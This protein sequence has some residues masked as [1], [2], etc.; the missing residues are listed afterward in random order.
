MR[1]PRPW[2]ALVGPTA[3]GKTEAGLVVAGR[4]GAEILSVDSMLVYRGM[5]VGTA[6]PTAEERARV[7]HHMLD[8]GAPGESFSVSRF[9][10]LA[11]RAL[12]D[13]G[14]RGCGV[15]LVGGSGLYFRS[16]VDGLS[17]PGTDPGTRFDLEREAE[18]LGPE[19][20]YARLA[21]LDPAAAAKIE[22]GN[23]RRTV[24]ALEVAAVTGRPFSAFAADWGRYPP[25]AVRAAGVDVDPA[26]LRARI[27]DRARSM[28][29]GGLVEEV[30]TLLERGAGPS[31]TSGQA[32]GYAEVIEHLT[33][34]M[35]LD[36]A[37]ARTVKRTRA[38]ARRQM[39]WFRRDPRIRWF[40]V[41]AEGAAGIV[42]ELTEYLR[43]G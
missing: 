16:V 5:D 20:L 26:A 15:L 30:R 3:S 32:I 12:E 17:F 31:L 37:V 28:V 23:V 8:V 42:D 29:A 19:R 24:R 6:K 18:A 36:A 4:L 39:A 1:P 25:G 10:A 33:G 14:G 21:A 9:Q 34:H 35:T 2:P 7:P 11:D 38:L 40:R 27:E 43:D 13:I 22:P 41:G